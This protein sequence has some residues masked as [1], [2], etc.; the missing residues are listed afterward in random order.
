[1]REDESKTVQ[2]VRQDLHSAAG[3][4]TSSDLLEWAKTILAS[5]PGLK[6]TFSLMINT[7]LVTLYSMLPLGKPF[8]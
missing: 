1:M 7:Y 6:V 2:P 3:A 5:Y 4:G 8:F